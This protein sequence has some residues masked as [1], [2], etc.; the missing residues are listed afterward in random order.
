MAALQ[1]GGLWDSKTSH[2]NNGWEVGTYLFFSWHSMDIMASLGQVLAKGT[3]V[4]AL[5]RISHF[6]VV[7]EP[8]MIPGHPTQNPGMLSS[9]LHRWR[10]QNNKLERGR[11]S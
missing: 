6:V 2:F 11:N 10:Q 4:W 1:V 7:D 3:L 5:G 8:V 9:R